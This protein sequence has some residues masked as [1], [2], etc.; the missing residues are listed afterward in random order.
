MLLIT[1]FYA[2]EVIRWAALNLHPFP[3]EARLSTS[4]NDVHALFFTSDVMDKNVGI[5]FAVA[6]III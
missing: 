2:V 5:F 6:A 3:L 4:G 1:R